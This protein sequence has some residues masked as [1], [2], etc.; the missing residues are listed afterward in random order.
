MTPI[1]CLNYAG[2]SSSNVATFGLGAVQ[3]QHEGSLSI[4]F[5]YQFNF[6]FSLK[7]STRV[8][9]MFRLLL[10]EFLH[11][12]WTKQAVGFYSL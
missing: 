8:Y 2:I 10:L 12:W 6:Q 9:A 1:S 4:C 3:V 11:G 7:P 5:Y